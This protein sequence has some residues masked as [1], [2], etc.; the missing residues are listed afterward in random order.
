M[1]K[2]EKVIQRDENWELVSGTYDSIEPSGGP[3]MYVLIACVIIFLGI[4]LFF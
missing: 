1:K 2:Q 3:L 4:I